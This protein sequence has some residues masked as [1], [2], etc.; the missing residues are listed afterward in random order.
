METNIIYLIRSG[1]RNAFEALFK[2]Y[3]GRLCEYSY[4]LTKDKD[5]SSEIVQDLFVN[6]WNNRF[7][8]EIKAVKPY[9]FKAVH[10]NTIKY[11]VKNSKLETIVLGKEYGYVMPHDF[12]LTQIL[13]ESVSQLPP[14]CREIF[15]LSRI[16]KMRHNEIAK[17]L[18]ISTRTV[19]VQIRKA[20]IILREQLKDFSFLL[21]LYFLK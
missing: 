3:Y 11:L 2:E 5:I 1:D 21:V 8:L 20:N 18:G 10:H 9:L 19:E 7:F 14:K 17:K 16:E 6:L 4:G 13:E 12:E 15:M